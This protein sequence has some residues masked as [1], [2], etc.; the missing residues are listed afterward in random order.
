MPAPALTDRANRPILD[1]RHVGPRALVHE[2]V[3]RARGQDRLRSERLAQAW[4]VPRWMTMSPAFS[5]TSESSR[6][7]TIS[8]SRTMP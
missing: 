3:E 2:P 1:L 4:S 8:P 5:C 6:I 7:S